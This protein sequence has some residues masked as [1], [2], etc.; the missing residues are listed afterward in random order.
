MSRSRLSVM[1]R[2][3]PSVGLAV[4][5]AL[6]LVAVVPY[7]VLPL[8]AA[9]VS[10]FD[11]SIVTNLKNAN[12]TAASMANVV[13]QVGKYDFIGIGNSSGR[14][15]CNLL[16]NDQYFYAATLVGYYKVTVCSPTAGQPQV[17]AVGN[18]LAM[19]GNRDGYEVPTFITDPAQM[20]TQFL[21]S[22]DSCNAPSATFKLPPGFTP[23]AVDSATFVMTSG[24]L[25]PVNQSQTVPQDPN[26]PGYVTQSNSMAF[27]LY[28]V[29][30]TNAQNTFTY[31]FGGNETATYGTDFKVS[32]LQNSNMP[33]SGTVT[34]GGGG[35]SFV[36]FPVYTNQNH[37]EK[38]VAMA[39]T[40]V[41]AGMQIIGSNQMAGRIL[42]LNVSNVSVTPLNGTTTVTPG[43]TTNGFTLTRTSGDQT[44]PLT[45]NY[46]IGGTAVNGTDYGYLSG[47][48]NIPANQSSLNIPLTVPARSGGTAIPQKDVSISL[49]APADSSYNVPSGNGASQDFTIPAYNPS[50]V[51]FA[52]GSGGG[53]L[54]PGQTQPFTVTR[55]GGDQTQPLT[56]NYTTGGT[57]Q[58]GTDYQPVSGTVTIPAN[59]TSATVPLSAIQHTGTT[60]YPATTLTITPATGSGYDASGAQPISYNI[61]AY[62]PSTVSVSTPTNGG[63]IPAGGNLP[64]TVMRTGDTSQPLTIPY[65]VG[66]TATA[67]GDYTQLPGSITIPAGATSATQTIATPTPNGSTAVPSK[68][69]TITP[70]SG[71]SY[72]VDPN[73]ATATYTTAAYTPSSVSAT[74]GTGG[75]TIT[76]GTTGGFTITR[77]GS[78]TASLPVSYTLGGTAV[79]GVDYNDLPGLVTIPAGQS[80]V[81]V[82]VTVPANTS[83]TS[84]PSKDILVTVTPGSGYAAGTTPTTDLTI[85]AAGPGLISAP[86][87]LP[88]ISVG[89]DP[90]VPAFTVTRTGGDPTQV[91]TVP[92]N[93]G[94]TG[95]PGVDYSQL[96]NAVTFPSGKTS[97]SVPVKLLPTATTGDTITATVPAGSG[98]IVGSGNGTSFSVPAGY[99]NTAST[100]TSGTGSTTASTGTTGTTTTAATTKKKGGSVLGS[101][102]FVAAAGAVGG[103]IAAST[104]ALSTG[105]AAAS[106]GSALAVPG[107]LAGSTLGTVPQACATTGETPIQLA[108]LLPQLKDSRP[109]WSAGSFGSLPAPT[110][111]GTV[112]LGNVA[113]TW[114]AGQPVADIVHV[115]DTAGTFNLHCLG[116]AKLAS[117]GQMGMAQKPL[118]TLNLVADTTVQ[119]LSK[120]LYLRAKTIGDVKGMAEWLA[121]RSGGQVTAA[122]LSG[123]SFA[124]ALKSYP[125]LGKLPMGALPLG[126]L[127]GYSD[128]LLGDIPNWK[129]ATIAQIVGL[130][131]VPFS[132]FPTQPKPLTALNK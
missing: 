34:F 120:T 28:V 112:K 14:Q 113:R 92:V 93:F 64:F 37:P 76:P 59:A 60:A 121:G 7:S 50:T 117:L 15:V 74:P 6:G 109:D 19:S 96:P 83:S 85:A 22:Y 89:F 30:P 66:G 107:L 99:G 126:Q 91:L 78:T 52:Q 101:A 21:G 102:G 72:T 38:T 98:Y 68:T 100:T 49:S 87:T 70:Q 16:S 80:A 82:P 33:Q 23:A 84:T 105:A 36:V 11:D 4:L 47:V 67:P 122:Q 73:N 65:T 127:P 69:I 20:P 43:S 95:V 97:V 81:T 39:I 44:Q 18:F 53:T 62:T 31:L 118:S 42:A 79:N 32:T 48:A 90:S 55:S 51:T 132:Q 130:K 9:T 46:T 128:L 77:T 41:P 125:E 104:G 75:S 88:V 2:R 35:G 86:T 8:R 12:L 106:T 58:P 57:A 13:C 119:G 103:T 115:G 25:N 110:Q 123:M 40:G 129:S 63:S 111:D 17:Y 54:T 10:G 26:N 3:L 5:G 116:L 56:V 1:S 27:G 108:Q 71:S 24:G 29:N 61:P 94:G 45:V 124:D 114:K 131:N